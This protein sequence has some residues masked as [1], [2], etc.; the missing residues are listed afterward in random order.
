[1]RRGVDVPARRPQRRHSLARGKEF[2]PRQAYHLGNLRFPA[3]PPERRSARQQGA[4]SPGEAS[5]GNKRRGGH[6]VWALSLSTRVHP[7]PCHHRSLPALTC[8][9]LG[10]RVLEAGDFPS[11]LP[12]DRLG[13]PGS[14]LGTRCFSDKLRVQTHRIRDLWTQQYL[15]AWANSAS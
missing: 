13:S 6:H 14:S 5:L 9:L 4:A 10:R 11:S 7:V 3:E 8:P 1:M 12:G 15:C 2:L